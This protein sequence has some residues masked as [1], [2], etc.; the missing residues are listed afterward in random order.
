MEAAD[1][2]RC[3]WSSIK[4]EG[5]VS[6]QAWKW[7][8]AYQENGER[9]V[10]AISNWSVWKYELGIM[11]LMVVLQLGCIAH[12]PLALWQQRHAS[13]SRDKKFLLKSLYNL[14]AKILQASY[15]LGEEGRK[16]SHHKETIPQFSLDL[17]FISKQSRVCFLWP[18][19][20]PSA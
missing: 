18:N 15:R 16:C 11:G 20:C 13:F 7:S 2:K 14:V 8:P 6:C 17:V 1:L 4:L 19:A 5:Y 10:T 12:F 9:L 3:S